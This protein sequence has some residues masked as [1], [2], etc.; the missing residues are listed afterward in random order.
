MFYFSLFTRPIFETCHENAI[1]KI[2]LV[3]CG[4]VSCGSGEPGD[5]LQCISVSI[6]N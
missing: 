1:D 6:F 3:E 5:T 4:L 2:G